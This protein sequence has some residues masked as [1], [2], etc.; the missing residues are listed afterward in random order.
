MFPSLK[1]AHHAVKHLLHLFVNCYAVLLFSNVFF[2]KTIMYVK[3]IY[4]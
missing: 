1:F 4:S 3:V 2:F